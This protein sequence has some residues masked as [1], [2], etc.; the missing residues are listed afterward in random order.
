MHL[1]TYPLQF[2]EINKWGRWFLPK[3]PDDDHFML[4]LHDGASRQLQVGDHVRVSGWW[5]ID[6]H[7]EFCKWPADPKKF[8]PTEPWRCR[9]RGWLLVGQT[10]TELHPFDWQNIRQVDP[11]DNSR[12]MISLAAPLYE[13]QYLGDWHHAANEFAGVSGHVF[14]DD[15]LTPQGESPNFH[16]G[17]SAHINLSAPPLPNIP[18]S[19]YR[20]L[21]WT[22]TVWKL[23]QGMDIDGVRSITPSAQSLDVNATVTADTG[24]G[25][26]PTIHGPSEGKWIVQL[27]YDVF[28]ALAGNEISCVTRGPDQPGIP[29]VKGPLI[30]IGGRFPSGDSWWL[31]TCEA[32]AAIQAG[33]HFY[34]S[35]PLGD[36]IDVIVIGTGTRATLGTAWPPKPGRPDPLLDLP[37]CI[38]PPIIT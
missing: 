11:N 23:G 15:D 8:N 38:N 4:K 20:K 9:P 16:T 36:P 17:V 3:K 33:H 28:W 30:G 35:S 37:S 5:V 7:P 19:S 32:L 2:G 1:E 29:P 26:R 12:C 10:H 21:K 24:D 18:A 6:H 14:I 31:R 34:V 13:Q 27:E 22:E 25:S